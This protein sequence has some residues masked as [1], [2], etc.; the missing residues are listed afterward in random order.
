MF[1]AIDQAFSV[2]SHFARSK[3]IKL[4]PPIVEEDQKKYF[5]TLFGDKNR[6]MQVII[7]FVSNSIKFSHRNSKIKLHLALIEAQDIS[8]SSLVESGIDENPSIVNHSLVS[9][10]INNVEGR[11]KI[12]YVHFTLTI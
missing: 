3:N 2:V 1:D 4:G 5:M 8:N 6:F 9:N 7:N 10:D 12:T 11:Q